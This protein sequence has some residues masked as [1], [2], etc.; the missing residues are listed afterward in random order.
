MQRQNDGRSN[1]RTT[2]RMLESLMRLAE[3]HAKLMFREEV[4]LEV[5]SSE[6]LLLFHLN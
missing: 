4:Q 6:G 3:A 5:L 1:A 2:V